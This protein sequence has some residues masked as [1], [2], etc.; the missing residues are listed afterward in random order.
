MRQPLVVLASV[1]VFM[2]AC[3]SGGSTEARSAGQVATTTRV[4]VGG[5][6]VASEFRTNA[7]DPTNEF[8]IEGTPDQLW[9]VLPAVFAEL[10]VP[11]TLRVQEERTIGNPEFRVRRQLGGVRL[12]RYLNCGD[13]LGNPNA[14]NYQLTIRIIAQVLGGTG[15]SARLMT[16]VDGSAKPVVGSGGPVS[17]ASSGNLEKRIVELVGERMKRPG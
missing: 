3:A 10:E 9:N 13:Q 12:S 15:E 8:E 2:G 17:C 1:S 6:G 16:V 14:D 11:V 4:D 5:T 7:S